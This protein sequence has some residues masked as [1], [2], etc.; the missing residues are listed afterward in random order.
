MRKNKFVAVIDYGMGNL[1]SVQ[2]GLEK[3][4][5]SAVITDKTKDIEDAHGV[6]LPGVG[7]FIDCMKNL[8]KHGLI[9]SILKAIVSGKPFMGICLGLQVLF[10][11]SEEFGVHPG[12]DVFKGRVVKFFENG[13]RAGEHLKVPH[14]G[15]NSVKIKKQPPELA[16]I[17]DGSYFY[18]VH[19]YYVKADD[20]A[21]VATTTQYGVEFVSSVCKDNV[22]ACQ[23][24]P[25]KSQKLGL[26][27]L[28]NFGKIV[29]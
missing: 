26:K 18:F 2:K 1:R 25:E 5:V 14:M 23:F 29:N 3:A 13:E 22:F 7:S 11:E 19:S 20:P 15:W 28:E 4:G 10:T 16:E 17:D 8:E 12:L 21:I 27:M 24:H 9:G 6:I